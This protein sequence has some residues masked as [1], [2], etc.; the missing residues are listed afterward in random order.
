MKNLIFVILSA[1]IFSALFFQDVFSQEI[2]EELSVKVLKLID[3]MAGEEMF[4]TTRNIVV[5]NESETSAFTLNAYLDQ[6][7]LTMTN[8]V[9][10]IV[11]IGNCNEDDELII[12]LEEGERIIKKSWNGFTCDDVSYFRVTESDRN[13]LKESP[14]SRIRFTNGRTF[15]SLTGDIEPRNKNYFIDLFYSIENEIFEEDVIE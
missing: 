2:T 8:L 3:P 4:T 7:D 10:D 1:S 6:E 13:L 12:L 11:N 14:I 9:V 15:D 5:I